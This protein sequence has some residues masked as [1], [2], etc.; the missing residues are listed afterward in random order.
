MTGLW[1]HSPN[2]EMSA[3][4]PSV[5]HPSVISAN[6][7]YPWLNSSA[8]VRLSYPRLATATLPLASLSHFF[9]FLLVLFLKMQESQVGEAVEIRVE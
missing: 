4:K 5:S 3:L 6:S 7:C 2:G 1:G 9:S 8:W